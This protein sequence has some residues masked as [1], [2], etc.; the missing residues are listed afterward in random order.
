MNGTIPQL[1]LSSARA[2]LPLVMKGRTTVFPHRGLSPH[3]FTPISGA[4]HCVQA[5]PGFA[6]LA[7]LIISIPRSRLSNFLFIHQSA[8]D[9]KCEIV[10]KR[11]QFRSLSGVPVGRGPRRDRYEHRVSSHLTSTLSLPPQ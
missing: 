9:D 2:I 4:H 8:S 6:L 10:K 3:Q 7:P 5:M 11:L 1:L